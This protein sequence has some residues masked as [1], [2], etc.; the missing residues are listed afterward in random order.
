MLEMRQEFGLYNWWG[1]LTSTF[2][3]GQLSD[4]LKNEYTQDIHRKDLVQSLNRDIKKER[5]R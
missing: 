3:S 1:I 4:K 5:T 2:I